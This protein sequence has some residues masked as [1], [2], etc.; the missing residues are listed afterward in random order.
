MLETVLECSVK[1]RNM[2]GMI[3][4]TAYENTFVLKP[5]TS[6]LGMNQVDSSLPSWYIGT[7]DPQQF[8]IEHQ[9]PATWRNH[10][11]GVLV[12]MWTLLLKE[13]QQTESECSFVIRV[14][15]PVRGWNSYGFFRLLFCWVILEWLGKF[16]N[17]F[18]VKSR[19]LF[20]Y[21][22]RLWVESNLNWK[23]TARSAYL[24]GRPPS[25]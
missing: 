4:N 17:D 14:Y 16:K 19:C 24:C 3:F 25:H 8:K 15:F 20:H 2:F 7:L 21:S 10:S 18:Q 9:N 11:A 5:P 12:C 1:F 22:M 13:I 23:F 6:P